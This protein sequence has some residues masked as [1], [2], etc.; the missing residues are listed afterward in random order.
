KRHPFATLQRAQLE[1]RSA[2]KEGIAVHVFVY[3]GTYYL[4]ETLKFL[5]EDSG[6]AEAQVIYEAVAGEEVIISGGRKLDL[7]WT[8]YTGAIMQ[9]T[10]IP[11]DLKLDQLFINSQQMHMARY[12]SFN[13]HTRIM[14]GYSRDCINPER[15][16]RWANPAGGYVHAMHKHLWGD[17]H[18]LIKGK[19]NN[20]QLL[21]EG[22]WQNNRQMGMHDDYRYVENI[23][24]ELDSPGEWF[25]DEKNGTL[26][27]YPYPE[28]ELHEAIVEGVF[29]AHLIEFCGSEDST[30]HHIELKGFTFKHATRTFMDNR[31]PLLRSDWTTYR[32]GA[33]VLRGS[34]NCSITD[35][36]FVHLGGNAVFVDSYNRNAIISG[37][38]IVDV[39]ANG[40]AF[41][42]D[43]NAVRS[44][45]FEYNDRQKLQDI[46]QTPGPKT[47]QYPAD[48]L[49]EDC[50]IH[51]IGRVES[52]P[53]LFKFPWHWTSPFDIAASMRYPGLES[54]F[55]RGHLAAM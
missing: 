26:Y 40:I 2:T 36:T 12:P 45:L 27:V 30:V 25:H 9:A 10:G 29:L 11:S 1:T 44:P 55:P 18:Y 47:N 5:P 19:E 39:G 17:Y 42:G 20:D 16:K 38:H 53:L 52:N 34:E 32:G 35:C 48:C 51:R 54:I 46:D 49:V 24:E 4:A 6:T 15:T 22:G 8:A 43:P 28:M 7:Q 3:G 23:F 33:I 31:E 14:N 21:L 13:E 50:L 41:V 37:C